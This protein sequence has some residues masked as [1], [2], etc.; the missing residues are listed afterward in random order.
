MGRMR[1]RRPL[2]FLAT[3]VTPSRRFAFAAVGTLPPSSQGPRQPAAR[4]IIDTA[5]GSGSWTLGSSSCL[6]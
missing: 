2:F 5:A 4:L 6:T 3:F 1:P